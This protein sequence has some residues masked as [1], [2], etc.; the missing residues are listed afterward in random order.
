M[1][2]Y[3]QSDKITAYGSVSFKDWTNCDSESIKYKLY[4]NFGTTEEI[5][6]VVIKAD[7]IAINCIKTMVSLIETREMSKLYLICQIRDEKDYIIA[8]SN[9]QAR[10]SPILLFNYLEMKLDNNN[11]PSVSGNIGYIWS[12]CSHS[13]VV[14]HLSC[15]FFD[16]SPTIDSIYS[17]NITIDCKNTS[18]NLNNG[19]SYFGCKLS[20]SYLKY[21]FNYT[22]LPRFDINN[23]IS[24]KTYDFSKDKQGFITT[25]NIQFGEWKE[26]N[27][28]TS[29]YILYCDYHNDD[30]IAITPSKVIEINC[31]NGNNLNIES[32]KV[33]KYFSC[34]IINKIN[35]FDIIYRY[36]QSLPTF[37]KNEI[38]IFTRTAIFDSSVENNLLVKGSDI[39]SWSGC[40]KDNLYYTCGSYKTAPISMGL[41]DLSYSK[42]FECK[43][44][45]LNEVITDGNRFYGCLIY[46]KILDTQIEIFA[47]ESPSFDMSEV[48]F[49]IE[50]NKVIAKGNIKYLWNSCSNTETEKY[51]ECKMFEEKPKYDQF[52]QMSVTA[53]NCTGSYINIEYDN[54]NMKYLACEIYNIND[55]TASSIK[56]I[57]LPSIYYYYYSVGIG[58]ISVQIHPKDITNK[59]FIVDGSILPEWD[60]SSIYQSKTQIFCIF[61]SEYPNIKDIESAKPLEFKIGEIDISS[62]QYTINTI[63][64]YF[65]CI[66]KNKETNEIYSFTIKEHIEL[67]MS[68]LDIEIKP[69]GKKVITGNILYTFDTC[70]NDN[71]YKYL[72]IFTNQIDGNSF[73]YNLGLPL[74][75]SG[76]DIIV[77]STGSN[78]DYFVC[79]VYN[80]HNPSNDYSI[81]YVSVVEP[82]TKPNPS[83]THTIFVII[84]ICVGGCL[85]IVLVGII[86]YFAFI[87]RRTIKKSQ[88]DGY[89]NFL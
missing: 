87:K 40:Y 72:C 75:C 37:S 49:S 6:G 26:C 20:D 14:V 77:T 23:I 70:N 22:E 78:D 42:Q 8:N 13:S 47:L 29:I 79:V 1:T 54:L 62:Y 73:D 85:L 44:I 63:H 35:D 56:Y 76:I 67:D 32:E 89:S 61:T 19:K 2:I 80:Q 59:Q 88:Y 9:V 34:L 24:N 86:V 71:Y 16:S 43:D 21:T 39:I 28:K 81:S 66:T 45:T 25:G 3:E 65:S 69:D 38:Q 52:D 41:F 10:K 18:I 60:S 48:K 50:N 64:N 55:F 58:M 83:S 15:D 33:K 27:S 5:D 7:G 74:E 53:I 11:K 31:A 82:T 84:G 30:Y 68:K 46:N 51:I 4:C 17:M 36:T 12:D 57:D